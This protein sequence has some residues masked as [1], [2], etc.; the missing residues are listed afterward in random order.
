MYVIPYDCV[1]PALP[2]SYLDWTSVSH[3]DLKILLHNVTPLPAAPGAVLGWNN[4]LIHWGGR[5][6]ESAASPRISIAA[7]FLAEGTRP[8]SGEIPV[9]DAKLPGFATRIRVIGQAMLAYEKFEPMMRR[10]RGLANKLIEW[11]G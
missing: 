8:G 11:G 7:E 10:Y 6:I 5:A 1:P 2:A 9:F 3:E 4:S